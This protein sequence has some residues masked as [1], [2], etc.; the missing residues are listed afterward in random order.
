MQV[1]KDDSN[2][3]FKYHWYLSQVQDISMEWDSLII[4]PQVKMIINI[5]VKSG[6]SVNALKKA[7]SQTI[8]HQ[9]IFKKIFGALLSQD[10]KFVK[11]TLTPNLALE[12]GDGLPCEYCKNF[13]ITDI[14][15][16][17]EWI[18]SLKYPHK[19]S[20]D[21]DYK[22]EYENLLVG[23]IG[24]SSLRQTDTMLEKI[25]DPCET[26]Q[27]TKTKVSASDTFQCGMDKEIIGEKENL[28]KSEYLC[29]MLTP[30]Q[31]IAVKD[32]SSHIIIEGDYGCGKTYVLKERAKQCAERYPKSKIVYIS[33][34]TD[35]RNGTSYDGI[36]I[37]DMIAENSFKDYINIDVLTANDLHDYYSKHK[38]ELI[39]RGIEFAFGEEERRGILKHFLNHS[40][41]DHMFLD[42]MPPSKKIPKHDF[43]QQIKPIVLP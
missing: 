2:S 21:E 16:I 18:E 38:K 30:E 40:N 34:T 14:M 27:A 7:A 29:Y 1:S 37:M 19:I 43:F 26:I 31:L 12:N 5:E 24:Y 8:I 33:Y 32:P 20:T 15:K 36:N 28:K 41:Y 22:V 6:P 42:E 23:I 3:F 25:V 39:N 9:K 4:L 10:W 11:T 13:M 35:L 17:G